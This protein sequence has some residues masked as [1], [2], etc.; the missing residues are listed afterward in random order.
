MEKKYFNVS[1]HEASSYIATSS[2]VKGE[3]KSLFCPLRRLLDARIR[4]E[5]VFTYVL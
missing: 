2:I 4:I 1:L 5:Y 3:Q